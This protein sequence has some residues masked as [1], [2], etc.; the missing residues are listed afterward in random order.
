MSTLFCLTNAKCSFHVLTV[1]IA[2]N[3]KLPNIATVLLLSVDD[4][5]FCGPNKAIVDEVK[6]HFMQKWEYKDLDEVGEFLYMHIC[7]NGHKIS[8]NQ[9]E[10]CGMANAKSMPTSLPAGY[11]PMP[12]T[13][14][15]NTVLQSRFQQMIGLLLYLSLGTCPDIAYAVTALVH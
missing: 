3:T 5:L 11:Y 8:I 6:A 12:S 10:H 7:Q 14:S 9:C 15:L 4:V 1:Y 13:K 2:Y